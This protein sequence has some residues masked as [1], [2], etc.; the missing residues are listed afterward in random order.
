MALPFIYIGALRRS[1]STI[2]AELLTDA[3]SSFI[4][5]EPRVARG[6][7]D[8]KPGDA[9]LMAGYGIDLHA[10]AKRWTG[11]RRRWV[12]RGF[13]RELYPALLTR[14]QQVGVKEISHRK[15]RRYDA[16]FPGMK[17]IVLA[18]DPRDI[19]LSLL[20]RAHKGTTPAQELVVT[21][22]AA[23]DEINRQFI[24]QGQM[25]ERRGAM[26]ITYE[27][28]CTDPG[29]FARVRDFCQSPLERPGG[30]GGFNAGNRARA[31]EAARHGGH[32]TPSRVARWKTEADAHRRAAADE[33][34]RLTPEFCAFWGYTR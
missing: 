1:G 32:V 11:P 7:F 19:Y 6:V 16:A 21:P 26:R 3:P 18:R 2:L 12:I 8:I 33:V 4:F 9:E 31:D 15:W 13:R 34:F 24:Y 22:Q 17:I 27:E 23:A 28:L 29:A 14:F 30:A 25:V 20:D 10:F 5:R